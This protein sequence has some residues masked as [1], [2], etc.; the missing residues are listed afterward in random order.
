MYE[1]C[2]EQVCTSDC[3][4]NSILADIP[5]REG[6]GNSVSNQRH[7]SFHHTGV[8]TIASSSSQYPQTVPPAGLFDL[9]CLA[10]H[11]RNSQI[12]GPRHLLSHHALLHTSLHCWTP[13]KKM[14]ATVEKAVD[15]LKEKKKAVEKVGGGCGFKCAQ[16]PM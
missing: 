5:D 2:H 10:R 1:A 4:S 9:H 3:D 8:P 12:S 11:V 15:T 6:E 16:V 13:D 7:P 14:K